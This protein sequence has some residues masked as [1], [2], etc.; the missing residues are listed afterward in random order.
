MHY[1][2]GSFGG[3]LK[4]FKILRI[5]FDFTTLQESGGMM[6]L[7]DVYCR[8]NR[9]RGLE[10]LSPEDLLHACHLLKGP[11]KLR[12][13]PSGA[14]VLQMESQDD[15]LT[16]SE[17]FNLVN[18]S[19][20]LAVEE[21]AKLQNISLLLAKERLLAAERL[22]KVCRDQSLEGLRFYPNYILNLPPV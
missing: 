22:G 13:F 9:A 1:A 10:L 3:I 7:A 4:I 6:S 5:L 21:F 16:A 12:N 18:K 19:T 14:M 2:P 17:T 20:S 15:E 11:I 8:I